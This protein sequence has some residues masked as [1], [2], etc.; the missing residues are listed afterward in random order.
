[1]SNGVWW[2][3]GYT[4]LLALLAARA[5]LLGSR[6]AVDPAGRQ[7][8]ERYLPKEPLARARRVAD[9][10]AHR[11]AYR[12]GDTRR[13]FRPFST[14]AGVPT[15]TSTYIKLAH[16]R[17][18]SGD[19]KAAAKAASKL[20]G[21]PVSADVLRTAYE[22]GLAA[23]AS[24]GHR[25]GASGPQWAAARVASLLVGG[26]AAWTADRDLFAQ[27][28]VK[29][30]RAIVARTPEVVTALKRDGRGRDAAAVLAATEA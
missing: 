19:P 16:A 14:D 21:A 26:K 3:V 17:G 20:Y 25:P 7:I 6:D 10:Y 30:R 27:L 8:P 24:G 18:L 23:W 1:M 22:R 2:A 29:A 9:L 5:P 4:G 13:A 28:P 15:K 12:Q 11:Q